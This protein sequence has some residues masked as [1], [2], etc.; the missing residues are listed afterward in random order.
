ME[1]QQFPMASLDSRRSNNNSTFSRYFE[2]GWRG[3]AVPENELR[4]DPPR[5]PRVD[6]LGSRVRPEGTLAA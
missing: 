3:G 2:V 1:P 5:S 4:E 6:S